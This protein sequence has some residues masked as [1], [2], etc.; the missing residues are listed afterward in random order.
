MYTTVED[1][2]KCLATSTATSVENVELHAIKEHSGWVCKR[3][4][5]TFKDGEKT[6]QLKVSKTNNNCINVPKQYIMDLV[7]CLGEDKLKLIQPGKFLFIP[8]SETVTFFVYLHTVVEKIVK[9]ALEKY[10]DEDILKHCLQVLS[11][12][13]E[14]YEEWFKVLCGEENDMHRAVCILILQRIVSMFVKSKQIIRE[15]LPQLK[16]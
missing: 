13:S 2:A 11:E 12:S 4:R 6:Y 3:V 9:E 7:K 14:L 8:T 10:A 15:Q 1:N 16:A 5:D